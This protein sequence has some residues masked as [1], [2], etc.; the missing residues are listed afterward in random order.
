MALKDWSRVSGT[1]RSWSN[2]EGRWIQWQ[3]INS[4]DG[5]FVVSTMKSGELEIIA[6]LQTKQKALKF[7]KEYMKT[8]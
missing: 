4:K 6:R 8:H 1:E 5:A 7:I 3:K 2:K